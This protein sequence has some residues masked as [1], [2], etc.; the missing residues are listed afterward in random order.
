MFHHQ[1]VLFISKFYRFVEPKDRDQ[2]K[3]VDGF[4]RQNKVY[5]KE[6]WNSEHKPLGPININDVFTISKD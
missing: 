1:E 4:S 2:V 5:V 6:V 3:T